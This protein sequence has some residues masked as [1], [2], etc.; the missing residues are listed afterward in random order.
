[1]RSVLIGGFSVLLWSIA[2]TTAAG[3]VT[4]VDVHA[5][6]GGI[7]INPDNTSYDFWHSILAPSEGPDAYDPLTDTLE[8][9]SLALSFSNSTQGNDRITIE[10][11]NFGGS[12]SQTVATLTGGFGPALLFDVQLTYLANEGLLNVLLLRGTGSVPGSSWSFMSSTLTATGTRTLIDQQDPPVGASAPEPASLL[13]LGAG[14]AGLA[15]RRR[16]RS[17]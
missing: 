1:M 12:L 10:L 11:A 16:R 7:T 14:L 13:L 3:P 5:P 4:F 2:T 8:D 6:N 15:A 17:L 9:A